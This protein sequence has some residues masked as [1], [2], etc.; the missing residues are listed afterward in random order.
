MEIILIIG[1]GSRSKEAGSVEGI[2]EKLHLLMHPGCD[3]TCVRTAYLQFNKPTITDAVEDAV[4]DGAGKIII[5]PYFLSSGIHVLKSIPEIIQKATERYP[6]VEFLYT[7]PIG[8]SDKMA[9]I[10]LE[11]IKDVL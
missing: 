7:E 10:I 6:G 11:K 4:K 3:N 5:H 8:T 1:H 2:A 9:E